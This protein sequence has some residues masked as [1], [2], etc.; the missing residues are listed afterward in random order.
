M[1][2]FKAGIQ[3]VTFD[4]KENIDSLNHALKDSGARGM[5]FSPQTVISH[6]EETHHN[7]TR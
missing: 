1:G 3:I 4:E 2:A 7:V 6:N 5:M